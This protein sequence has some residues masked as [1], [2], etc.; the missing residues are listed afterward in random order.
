M[1]KPVRRCFERS[2]F[3]ALVCLASFASSPSF[4][5]TPKTKSEP[6]FVWNAPEKC[7]P[8]AAVLAEVARL[9]SR[10]S[11]ATGEANVTFDGRGWLLVLKIERE[12]ASPSM[13]EYTVES[14]DAAADAAALIFAM[15]LDPY[16]DPSQPSPPP[17]AP[18]EPPEKEK[19]PAPPFRFAIE[20]AGGVDFELLPRVSITTTLALGVVK[21]MWRL[22][23]L[24]NQTFGQTVGE[25]V[26]L[27]PWGGGLRGCAAFLEE[28]IRLEACGAA[29]LNAIHTR[30]GEKTTFEPFV[31]LSPSGGVAVPFRK[32]GNFF[33]VARIES[34]FPLARPRFLDHTNEL[35]RVDPI[36]WRGSVGLGVFLP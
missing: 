15:A 18:V 30:Q 7:P 5:A 34:L 27:H 17:A 10:G 11:G 1:G 14:C 22:D 19:K 31:G 6:L 32:H 36:V 35:H 20:G 29:S 8:K 24:G 16:L 4:A 33:A 3:V 12:N 21:G 13:R 23:L 28:P 2:A 25:S 9:T 26:S